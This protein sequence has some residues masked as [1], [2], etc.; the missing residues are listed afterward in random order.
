MGNVIRNILGE[1]MFVYLKSIKVKYFPSERDKETFKNEKI[2]IERR[3]RL[4]SSLIKSGELC[5]DVGANVGNR[6]EPLL[7]IGAKVL[8]VEPQK[9][10]YK[11]LH[12]KFGNR[13]ILIKK[14]LSDQ[15]GVKKFY[16]SDA[17]VL[18]TY[19][20][21]WITMGKKDRFKEHKWH[22]AVETEMTT[23]DKLIQQY[24]IPA[25]IKIDVEGYELEVLKGL[26]S[27]IKY[28]SFEYAVPEQLQKAID[29]VLRIYFTNKEIECN[30]S[31]GE[32]MELVLDN[33][34][35]VDQMKEYM[36]S[37]KFI[38]S[39]FGDIYVR[40]KQHASK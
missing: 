26:S 25:F 19:S 12:R 21:E 3:K 28:I 31:V 6:V 9:S 39:F 1:S 24:G 32:S 22:K 13:I 34:L 17:S 35:S 5:F 38:N 20:E 23:L 33:W 15:E 4:F 16:I 27:P 40:T 7:Q 2:A 8:A 36:H 37:G 10:C 14:G 29:C 30:Y 18:S 11:T